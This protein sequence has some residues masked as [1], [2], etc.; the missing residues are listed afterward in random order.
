MNLK[1]R[2]RSIGVFYCE[3]CLSERTDSTAGEL[4]EL[5]RFFTEHGCELFSR[6]YVNE[7]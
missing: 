5:V 4:R 3:D 2:G 6:Q 7:E 1:I